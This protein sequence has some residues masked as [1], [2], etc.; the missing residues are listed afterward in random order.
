MCLY[1]LA[2]VSLV[3]ASIWRNQDVQRRGREVCRCATGCPEKAFDVAFW[4]AVFAHRRRHSGD[5]R[6]GDSLLVELV[7]LTGREVEIDGR[8]FDALDNRTF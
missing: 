4:L 8:L 7:E 6:I 1:G 3:I 5:D 2:E